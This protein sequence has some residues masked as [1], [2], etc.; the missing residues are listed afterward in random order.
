MSALYLSKVNY[1]PADDNYTRNIAYQFTGNY[2]GNRLS[3]SSFYK[4]IKKA[5]KDC[6]IEFNVALH[7]LRKGFGAVSYEMHKKEGNSTETLR[8]IFNH[9]NLSTT[10]RYI[11]NEE[12]R[13]KRYYQ[14]MGEAF[15]KAV[16]NGEEVNF[17]NGL[18]NVGDS[19]LK[20]IITKA[21]Q[22]GLQNS[23]ETDL[24]KHMD[25]INSILA[26]VRNNG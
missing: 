22:V 7:S 23:N 8:S 17:G 4:V 3:D 10:D 11:G 26:E 24:M 9:S 18:E 21:Y 12:K 15:T 19:V 20:M 14:D 13:I 16:V 2:K 25:N 6:G 5:A 1:N